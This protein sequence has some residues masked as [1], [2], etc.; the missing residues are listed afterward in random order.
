MDVTLANAD[1]TPVLRDA[2]NRAAAGAKIVRVLSV[3]GGYRL[4]AQDAVPV[5]VDQPPHRPARL[6]TMQ[7]L[8]RDLPDL[9]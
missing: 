7:S 4:V 8:G 9:D 3:Q 2:L 6:G 1:L 5:V